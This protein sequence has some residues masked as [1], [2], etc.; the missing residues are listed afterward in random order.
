MRLIRNRAVQEE[1]PVVVSVASDKPLVTFALPMPPSVNAC[2]RNVKMVGRV[3]TKEY[4]EWIKS[5]QW[6][7]LFKSAPIGERVE[8]RI[9]LNFSK[10]AQSSSDID[11]RIKPILDLFVASKILEDDR[12]SIVRK[13]SVELAEILPQDTCFV[14]IR[15]YSGE[16][17]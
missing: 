1:L 12:A 2:Y 13:V 7:V 11:N 5:C 9:F 3:K 10:R 14:E 17:T 6:K 15:S 4:L 8:I 16:K